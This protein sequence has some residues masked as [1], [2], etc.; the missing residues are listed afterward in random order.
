[1]KKLLL[2]AGLLSLLSLFACNHGNDKEEQTSTPAPEATTIN[3]KI[4]D[5]ASAKDYVCGMDVEDGAI[6]DTASYQGKLYGFC[7]TECKAEFI[8]SPETY[9]AQK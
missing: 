5:L 7:S 2:G 4:S 8:K 1:M 3:V 9:L 6:A